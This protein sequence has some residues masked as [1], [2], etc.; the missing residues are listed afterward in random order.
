[1]N[2]KRLLRI[3]GIH[4]EE[5]EKKEELDLKKGPPVDK[6]IRTDE[7]KSFIVTK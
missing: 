4:T 5:E 6:M 3:M 7:E 2:L 1:M